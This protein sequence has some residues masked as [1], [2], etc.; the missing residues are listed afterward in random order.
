MRENESDSRTRWPFPPVQKVVELTTVDF[1]EAD[2]HQQRRE[3]LGVEKVSEDV[4]DRQ[5][6]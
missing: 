4:P 3:G 5:S 1:K 2:K 6:V